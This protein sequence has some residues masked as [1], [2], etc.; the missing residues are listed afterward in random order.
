MLDAAAAMNFHP[1]PKAE[2]E[3]H[4]QQ[5]RQQSLKN[6]AASCQAYLEQVLL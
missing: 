6:M 4:D 1:G 3:A 5:F 2:T